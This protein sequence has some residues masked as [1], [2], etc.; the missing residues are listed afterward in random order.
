[1]IRFVGNKLLA[2][3]RTKINNIIYQSDR[4]SVMTR[5]NDQIFSEENSLSSERYTQLNNAQSKVI[6]KSLTGGAVF[7]ATGF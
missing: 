6:M 4:E 7:L 3:E 5:N 2:S 1:M